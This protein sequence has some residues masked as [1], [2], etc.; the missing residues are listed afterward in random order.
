MMLTG[1]DAVDRIGKM[2]ITGDVVP[3]IW[4][5]KITYASGKP[6]PNAI[7]ILADIVY[8]FRPVEVRDEKT[9]HVIGW[10]KKFAADLLQRNY[11]DFADHFG[12]SKKQVK[13]AMNL[14]E[15]MGLIYRE[16]RNVDTGNR[17]VPNVLYIGLCPERLSEITFEPERLE[18][19]RLEMSIDTDEGKE[20]IRQ[21]DI[22]VHRSIHTTSSA[23]TYTSSEGGTNTENTTEIT[24]ERNPSIDQEAYK[25]LI[26][27]QIGYDCLMQEEDIS[28]RG[29][30]EEM[31]LLICDVVCQ[32]RESIRIGKENLPYEL[33]KSRFLKLEMR[34]L[35]YA[36]HTIRQT[37]SKIGNIRAYLLTTLYHAPETITTY[38]TQMATHDLAECNVNYEIESNSKM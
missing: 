28:L 27:D 16:L 14:L 33:V 9:G 37:T 20:G 8:W 12:F 24:T 15:E 18:S 36:A 17:I 30:Y 26:R 35:Q 5:Q 29:M 38:W 10:K 7:M 11:Q 32:A 6:N 23:C 4:F 2:N 34:H 3:T 25:Q 31:Y 21:G 22:C 19:E 1:N 13:D